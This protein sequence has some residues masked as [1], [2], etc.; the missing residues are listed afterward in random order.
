MLLNTSEAIILY[1]FLP[2][3]KFKKLFPKERKVIFSMDTKE[4]ITE[5]LN[6]LYL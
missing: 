1:R 4:R 3:M 6:T 5:N 2:N